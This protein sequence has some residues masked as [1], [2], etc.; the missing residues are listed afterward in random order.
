MEFWARRPLPSS[1]LAGIKVAMENAAEEVKRAADHII[2]DCDQD[3]IGP[4]LKAI[5]PRLRA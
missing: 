3:P 4:Y 2:G 1:E 5:F